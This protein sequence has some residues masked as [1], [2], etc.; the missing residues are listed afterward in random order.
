MRRLRS[1]VLAAF[2]A[3]SLPLVAS[4]GRAQPAAQ[5]APAANTAAMVAKVQGFYDKTTS[6]QSEFSQEFFVKS[7]NVRKES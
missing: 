4:D 1:I 7:H 3:A 2:F 6:F 5:A